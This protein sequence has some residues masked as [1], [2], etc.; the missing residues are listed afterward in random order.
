LK[1]D[2]EAQAGGVFETFDP[3]SYSSQ[4]VAG[5]NYFVKIDVGSSHIHARI[6]KPLP[7]TGA[8][9]S[10]HSLQTGKAA[11]SPMEYF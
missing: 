2:I 6:Y 3:V 10:L 1:G 11:D 5:T 4:V 9:P 7:H 8:A